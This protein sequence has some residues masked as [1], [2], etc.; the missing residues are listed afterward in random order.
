MGTLRSKI[1]LL[2]QILFDFKLYGIERT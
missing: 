1:S 2:E